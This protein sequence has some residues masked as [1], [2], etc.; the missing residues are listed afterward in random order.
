[1]N[2]NDNFKDAPVSVT[3]HR[4]L[5]EQD[6]SIWTPRDVLIHALRM[7]DNGEFDADNLVVIWRERK[8]TEHGHA[9]GCLKSLSDPDITA[10]LLMRAVADIVRVD[11]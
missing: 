11:L 1:M 4:S 6:G 7:L 9:M 10:G 8:T 2:D 5:K 3:E